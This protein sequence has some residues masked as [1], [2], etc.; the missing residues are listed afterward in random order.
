MAS[1]FSISST[2]AGFRPA[3]RGLRWLVAHE[4]NARVHAAATMLVLGLGVGLRVSRDD[5]CW[6]VAALGAVW[7][8]EAFNT[9]LEQLANEVN[10]APRERIGRAKDLAAGAVLATAVAAAL[11]GGVILGPPLWALISR[12]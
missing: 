8:A 11:I 1:R 10:E 5:W 9:A 4:A 2:L 6:L 7:M 12:D 3:W